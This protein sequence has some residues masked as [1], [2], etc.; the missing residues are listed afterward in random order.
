MEY[1]PNPRLAKVVV[2]LFFVDT[3]RLSIGFR[4]F[5]IIDKEWQSKYTGQ[6]T[7]NVIIEICQLIAV[8]IH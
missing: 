1:S 8:Q 6:S 7:V 4:E 3:I 5:S 2:H